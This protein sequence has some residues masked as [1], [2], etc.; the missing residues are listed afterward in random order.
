MD[1]S[2][3][4]LIAHLEALRQNMEVTR[5]HEPDATAE[6]EMAEEDGAPSVVQSAE[7]DDQKWKK[8]R[9]TL[10]CCRELIR[11]EL[12]Y[13][14]G[15]LQLENGE[16]TTPPPKVLGCYLPALV[17]SSIQLSI[18]MLSDPTAYGVSR[19]FIEAEHQL[20]NAF[21]SWCG[22]IGEGLTDEKPPDSHRK[23]TRS[24]KTM[25]G[26]SRGHTRGHST[27]SHNS[28]IVKNQNQLGNVSDIDPKPS[29][30]N[31]QGFGKGNGVVR[32]FKRWSLHSSQNSSPTVT[33]DPGPDV[34]G[35]TSLA[36]SEPNPCSQSAPLPHIPTPPHSNQRHTL[37][38]NT[39]PTQDSLTYFHDAPTAPT[40]SH[41]ETRDTHRP[42]HHTQ[43][44]QNR[45]SR[46]ANGRSRRARRVA[47]VKD[48]AIQP[49]Q[50]VMRYV[51]LY[52]DILDHTTD[53][54]SRLSVETALE[55]A[56]RIATKCDR[57]QGNAAFLRSV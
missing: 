2:D 23:L 46:H 56:T 30:D 37:N 43:S 19:A 39:G 45:G 24:A 10:F 13:L 40:S 31:E 55:S 25:P 5:Q 26:G 1:V 35:S 32:L 50:R 12:S 38:P 11:T 7:D 49:T 51:L 27:I 4:V 17:A 20:E 53:S 6:I 41:R 52:R 57:A 18:D 21:V 15:L 29:V 42:H 16:T 8:A 33:S 9:T 44:N 36:L 28:V 22:I 48:L 34:G 47:T 14:E 3:D 54:S